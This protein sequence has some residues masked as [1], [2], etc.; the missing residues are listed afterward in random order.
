MLSQAISLV[1]LAGAVVFAPGSAE[2]AKPPSKAARLMNIAAAHAAEADHPVMDLP[3]DLRRQV[4]CTALNVYHEARG[5]TRRD[6]ISVALVTRNRALHEQRSYCSVVWERAQFSWTR[7]KVQRLVPRDDAAWDRALTRAMAVVADP[8]PADITR[9]ARHF[10]NP[11]LVR[12]RWA[13]PGKV[14]AAR[15]IG[16]HRYV[17]LRDARWYK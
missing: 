16:Q 7:Y 17:R 12:P 2:A 4:L 14:V 5:S 10:Y 8:S 15:R 9:G 6:Q 11:R 13:R 3:P 1:C